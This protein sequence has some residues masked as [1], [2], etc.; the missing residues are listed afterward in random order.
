LNA[1]DGIAGLNSKSRMQNA[2]ERMAQAFLKS[3]GARAEAAAPPAS[4]KISASS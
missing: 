1:E 2:G 3:T 4:I